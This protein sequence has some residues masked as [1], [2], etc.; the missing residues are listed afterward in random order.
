MKTKKEEIQESDEAAIAQ[1]VEIAPASK[2][3]SGE[4]FPSELGE[5]RW[6]VVSFENCIEAGLTYD[7]AAQKLRKLA[8]ED[9]SG[10]CIV[11]DEAAYR[12]MN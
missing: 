9:I 8:A 7:E 1:S 3:V 2:A 5:P 10:L 11:T 6:A 12:I 4:D